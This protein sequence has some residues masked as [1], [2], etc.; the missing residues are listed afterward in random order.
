[1]KK[2]K[3][4]AK[5]LS[6]NMDGE[7]VRV[8]GWVVRTRDLGKI[9]FVIVRDST[10]EFQLTFKKGVVSDELLNIAKK[11]TTASAIITEGVI[12]K[13]KTKFGFEIIPEKIEVNFSAT[14]LPVDI[15]GATETELSKRIKWRT[16]DLRRPKAVAIFKIRSLV[17]AAIREFFIKNNF[18]EI[19]TPSIGI[20][21][22]EGG[23]DVF[24]VKYFDKKAYLRQSPQLYKQLLVGALEKVF[25]ISPAWRAEPHWTTRHL[26]EF[27][28]VDAEIAWIN[29]IDDVLDVL[30][31]LIIY[32]LE[33]V[34]KEGKGCFETLGIEPP[35]VPSKPFPRVEYEDAVKLLKK[36][37]IPLE[38]KEIPG[39]GEEWLGKHIKEKYGTDAFFIIH[40]PYEIR[41][42]YTMKLEKNGKTLTKSFDLIYRGLEIA[43]G[44]QREHRYDV[45]K[46]Q[47]V[48][49]GLRPEAFGYYLEAFKYGMP[50]HGGFGLGLDRYTARILQIENIREVILYPRDP[51]TLEP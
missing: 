26:C 23:A 1:M 30:E 50:P 18:V 17:V 45:L 2:I 51:L 36:A 11:L 33:K 12:R 35:N 48:E 39:K 21:S 38:G 24:E 3:W 46:Q 47:I 41:P 14:P 6:P 43:S 7:R 28:S 4:F 49:K 32:T 44:A 31:D 37:G 34:R 25:E 5:E 15:I 22:A 16:L 8:A 20:Y 9:V 10:G 29:G 19:H 27:I 42:F 13:A 40:F